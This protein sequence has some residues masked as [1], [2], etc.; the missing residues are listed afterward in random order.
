MLA[1]TVVMIHGTVVPWS[2][3]VIGVGAWSQ[4][5]TIFPTLSSDDDDGEYEESS[6]GA[7]NAFFCVVSLLL[8]KNLIGHIFFVT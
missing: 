4:L 3:E 8:V 2:Q 5:H 7:L 1:T 6:K